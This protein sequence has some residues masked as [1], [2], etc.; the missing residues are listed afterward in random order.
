MVVDP[1]NGEYEI[2]I[3]TKTIVVEKKAVSMIDSYF[4]TE[5]LAKEP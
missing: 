3:A 1:K 4:Q 2:D 5:T